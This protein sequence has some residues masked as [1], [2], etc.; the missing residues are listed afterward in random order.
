M[1]L[2]APPAL[3]LPPDEDPPSYAPASYNTA[4]VGPHILTD[5]KAY[6]AVSIGSVISQAP[7]FNP[8]IHLA[9]ETLGFDLNVFNSRNWNGDQAIPVFRMHPGATPDLPFERAE[10]P[11]YISVRPKKNS[12]SCALV[13]GDDP[14]Q[15]PLI[16]TVYR[17]GPG[18]DPHMR[19]YGPN[20]QISVADAVDKDKHIANE[21][22]VKTHFITSRSAS[23]VSPF[24][25][26]EWRY[27]KRSEKKEYAADSLLVCDRLDSPN[28]PT[29]ASSSSKK[30]S[31]VR[32]AQLIR[33]EEYRAQ[34]SKKRW[35][36][37]NGGRLM[38]DLGDWVGREKSGVV[39]E[40]EAV[41]VAGCLLMLKRETD[42]QKDNQLAAIT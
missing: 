5:E 15:T 24:G 39:E 6:D 37:G 12:N 2:K 42:R 11:E 38:L 25:K 34:G 9:I 4:N 22:E 23:M 17:W 21:F 13:R 3:N 35:V 36:G 18:R 30:D 7:G 26:F 28:A 33:N 41:L 27:G 19:I 14:A 32:I 8:T 29:N 10:Q 16:S 1:D 20:E 31:R 40:V